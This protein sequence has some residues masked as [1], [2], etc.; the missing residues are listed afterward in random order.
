R[1]RRSALSVTSST[2]NGPGVR[3]VGAPRLVEMEYKWFRPSCSDEKTIQSLLGNKNDPS[4]VSSGN[5]S[6]GFVPLCQISVAFPFCRSAT[7]TPQ[8]VTRKGIN[9]NFC[10]M[11]G[12]RMKAMR[13][14]SGDHRG[15]TSR[16]TLGERYRTE[17]LPKS[18][19]A[20]KLW[21]PRLLTK[22]IWRP[23]GDHLGFEL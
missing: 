20:T 7:Q 12:I 21:S 22:A 9:G 14:P 17:S 1:E 16:S 4:A 23:S 15:R 6:S 18:Y 13:R 11:P 2:S 10:S 5:E 3:R 19:T 8:G